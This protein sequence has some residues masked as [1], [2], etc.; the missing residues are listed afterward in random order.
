ML[1][2]EIKP[3][4]LSIW[5]PDTVG[6]TQFLSR[7]APS[8]LRCTYDPALVR[9]YSYDSLDGKVL[10]YLCSSPCSGYGHDMLYCC[11][12]QF[13]PDRDLVS[14]KVQIYAKA[15]HGYAP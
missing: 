7:G 11:Q 15:Y 1:T 4:Q 2:A 13:K 5:S 3:V 8:L 10:P 6:H 9:H 12:R 14:R